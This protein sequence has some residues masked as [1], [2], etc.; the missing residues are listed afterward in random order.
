MA[1]APGL[2][3]SRR[4]FVRAAGLAS[5]G[6]LAGCG[7]LPGQEQ[8][9]VR[10]PVVGVLTAA[11]FW[12]DS[13]RQ[14]LRDHGYV[15][16]QNVVVEVR[17]SEGQEEPL[18]DYARELARLPA[19]VIVVGGLPAIRAAMAATSRIPVVMVAGGADAVR[20]GLVASL[21]HPGGNVTG[22]TDFA[23]QLT[24]KRLELIC[25]TVPGVR[26]VGVV[27]VPAATAEQWQEATVAA[28]QLGIALEALDVQAPQDLPTA[29]SIAAQNEYQ[30]IL[31][32]LDPLT[33]LHQ[34]Q[35]GQLTLA[36]HQPAIHSMKGFAAAGGLLAYGPSITDLARRAAAYADKILKGAS[37][38]DL[39]VEQPTTFDFVINL[40]TAQALGLT[41][42]QHVL[43]Q[44]TEMIP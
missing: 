23:E 24:A 2:P 19:D 18:A 22:L 40:Q 13:F 9:S 16:G 17:S 15:E 36:N 5:L 27:R 11:T 30:A 3:F 34:A 31:L 6:L 33:V 4:G 28:Q 37:P 44:A 41:I 7:R 43:L 42:P 35:L 26:R 29:L 25:D 1:A 20:A 8:H 32:L 21:A 10:M 12:L 38:A 14:A 39:P